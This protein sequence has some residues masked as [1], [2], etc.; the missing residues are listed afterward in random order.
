MAVDQFLQFVGNHAGLFAALGAIAALLG[1]T[2]LHGRLQ[3][4]KSVS[5][6]EATLLINHEDAVVI[7]VRDPHELKDGTILS[8]IHVPIGQL[9]DS[10]GKLEKY[11]ERP[12]IVGCRSGSRSY[13][14][15]ATLARAG[16]SRV[17][18]LRGGV[19]AW[20]N[21]SLPLVRK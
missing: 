17:Y 21:A 16:F 9:K 15:C 1:W 7:D 12:V 10:L 18:N 20:Q 11:K 5:P 8:S 13:S 3:G 2:G 4:V 19:M 6:A 14:A